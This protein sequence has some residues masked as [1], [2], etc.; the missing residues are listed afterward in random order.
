MYKI[1]EIGKKYIS[2]DVCGKCYIYKGSYKK[3]KLNCYTNDKN[4]DINNLDYENMIEENIIID[5][6][7]FYNENN[8][9][10]K[11]I[12]RAKINNKI[13][14]RD[15]IMQ[16]ICPFYLFFCS[17]FLGFIKMIFYE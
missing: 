15:E 3:H 4:D 11:D 5:N 6:F 10:Y 13:L 7:C 1:I 12:D 16:I 9:E 2:C 14:N 17:L 8:A